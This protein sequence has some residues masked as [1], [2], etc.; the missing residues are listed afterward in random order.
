MNSINNNETSNRRNKSKGQRPYVFAIR[1]QTGEVV[2]ANREDLSKDLLAIPRE[3]AKK[4]LRGT[5][6]VVMPVE[7]REGL[8][9]AKVELKELEG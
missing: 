4:V 1:R 3:V 2:K 9:A 8:F 7:A 5:H 6:K